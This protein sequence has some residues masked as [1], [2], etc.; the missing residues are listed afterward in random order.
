MYGFIDFAILGLW[1]S[2]FL[3]FWIFGFV[4]IELLDFWICGCMDLLS[5]RFWDLLIPR[6]LF[7]FISGK[8]KATVK[9]IV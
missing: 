8:V 2:G 1:I 9:A 6:F 7:F 3:D 4:F 5:L